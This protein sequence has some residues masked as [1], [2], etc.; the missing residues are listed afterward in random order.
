MN[1]S[2]RLQGAVFVPLHPSLGDRTRCHLHKNKDLKLTRHPLLRRLLQ[3]AK[4]FLKELVTTDIE[5]SFRAAVILKFFPSYSISN[6]VWHPCLG[7][8]IEHGAKSLLTISGSL[9]IVVL[10]LDAERKEFTKLMNPWPCP[11]PSC[12]YKN[13]RFSQ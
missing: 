8:W 1:P 5:S 2:S 3:G 11:A 13:P 10:G 12:T 7:L 6:D 9:C 4:M